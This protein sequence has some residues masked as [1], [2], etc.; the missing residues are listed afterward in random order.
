MA[1]SLVRLQCSYHTVVP[2][3]EENRGEKM[4]NLRENCA[5]IV[6]KLRAN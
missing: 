6:R 3:P 5:K 2:V 4:Q 1:F